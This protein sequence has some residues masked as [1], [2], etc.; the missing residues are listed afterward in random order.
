MQ[1]NKLFWNATENERNTFIAQSLSMAGFLNKD[2]SLWG[3]S[4]GGITSGEV[5]IFIKQKNGDPFSIVEALNLESLDKTYLN[6]HLEKIFYYDT[7]GLKY[8]FILVYSTSKNFSD[9]WGRYLNYISNFDY[10]F[11]I[12]SC[13]ELDEFDYTDIR[14]CR[15]LHTRNGKETYL[16]HIMVDLNK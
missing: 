16:Y 13:E 7:T 10:P 2:Q 8:N 1:G 4:R 15:T 11:D 14:I 6:L 12:S 3:K 9:F 5:D